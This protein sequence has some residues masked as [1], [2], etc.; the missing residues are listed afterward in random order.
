[1]VWSPQYVI[2]SV[3]V[4]I[5]V[6]LWSPIRRFRPSPAPSS[7]SKV[8]MKSERGRKA[9]EHQ[10]P[11]STA[12]LLAQEPDPRSAVAAHKQNKQ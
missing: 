1:M 10:M 2:S 5:I 12:A 9:S 4:R 8:F 11:L 7:L 3:G 6:L